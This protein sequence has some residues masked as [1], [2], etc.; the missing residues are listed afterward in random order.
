MRLLRRVP[1]V[2]A[3]FI[4]APVLAELVPG[5]LTPKQ[6]F[7]PRHL[8][9]NIAFYGSGAILARELLV[10]WKKGWPTLLALGAAYALLEEGLMTKSFFNP[11]WPELGMDSGYGRLAGVNWILA[12]R[13]IIYHSVLSISIPVVLAHFMFPKRRGEPWI[14][15]W[16]FAFFMGCLAAGTAFGY[17][18]ATPYRPPHLQYA[19]GWAAFFLL[20]VVAR[21]LPREPFKLL[22]RPRVS[23]WWFFLLGLLSPLIYAVLAFKLPESGKIPAWAALLLLIGF[24]VVVLWLVL[25]LSGN[26]GAWKARQRFALPAGVLIFSIVLIQHDAEKRWIGLAALVFVMAMARQARRVEK[27]EEGQPGSNS[28]MGCEPSC[29]R[30]R[31]IVSSKALGCSG[32]SRDSC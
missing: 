16:A 9:L 31:P 3:L 19:L 32:F 14:G 23:R 7:E 15:K 1:P 27:W 5:Y 10:R 29:T 11:A 12:L 13:L 2:L 26:C 8:L 28:R 24:A 21:R 22:D 18:K 20:L 4:M 30:Q 25:K 17:F 6:F